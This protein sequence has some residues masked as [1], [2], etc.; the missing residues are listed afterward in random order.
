MCRLTQGTVLFLTVIFLATSLGMSKGMALCYCSDGHIH[1]ALTVEGANCR[2]PAAPGPQPTARQHSAR[3]ITTLSDEGCACS[4]IHST[5]DY[6]LRR[7]SNIKSF[8]LKTVT[9]VLAPIHF[10]PSIING[11]ALSFQS[12]QIVPPILSLIHSTILQI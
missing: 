5:T 7:S 9:P 12:L 4:G 6:F 1:A 2:K 10:L 8:L 11:K 3:A